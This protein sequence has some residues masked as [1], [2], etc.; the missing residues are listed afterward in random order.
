MEILSMWVDE[1]LRLESVT[2]AKVIKLV[3]KVISLVRS[4]SI[5]YDFRFK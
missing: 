4:K 1:I 5:N 2:L 3:A